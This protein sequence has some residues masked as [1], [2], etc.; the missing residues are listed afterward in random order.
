MNYLARSVLS[1]LLACLALSAVQA[2]LPGPQ[3]N[4]VDCVFRSLNEAD[5]A[6]DRLAQHSLSRVAVND[7]SDS[8]SNDD[9]P[10]KKKHRHSE[11]S[12]DAIVTGESYKLEPGQSTNG[13]VVLIG[14]NGE[15]NGTI[16]GDLVLIGSKAN[17]G[18]T[19]NG[20]FVTIGSN[21]L[22]K[23]GAVAN[24]DYVSV[25]SAVR[26]E[27]E[28]T[29]NGERVTLN[30]YSPAVPVIKEA[31]TNIVQLRP[32]SPS[33][34]FSWILAIIML[35]VSLV[36]GLIF[37]QVFAVTEAIVR[38]RPG[39]SLLVGL[40]VIL[41][42]TVLS[43][44]LAITVVGIIALPFLALVFLVLNLFGCTLVCYSI[45]KRIAPQAT[46]RSYAVY[47]W[48][49]LGTVVTWVLYC[50]PIIGFL[51]AG[52]ASLLGLG[53]FAIYLVERFRRNFF[54]VSSRISSI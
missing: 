26:G 36:L 6:L 29:T 12:A 1:S 33:S 24:G 17:F 10:A 14:G 28:L 45:G 44:L 18:G 53:T 9:P 25:A 43:F 47:V 51:A 35:T 49:I 21:L 42:G 7:S 23:P 31:L 38:N 22:F 5:L 16:N 13:A 4:F 15:I 3:G 20:D 37:P 50:I 40:A 19:V 48:I 39:N 52:L 30:G 8:A 54:L 27:E 46:N 41:G 34:V 2:R 32:M 11:G